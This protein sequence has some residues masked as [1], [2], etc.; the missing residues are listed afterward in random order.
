MKLILMKKKQLFKIYL[1]R[2]KLEFRFQEKPIKQY[3]MLL[4]TMDS[5]Q[6]DSPIFSVVIHLNSVTFELTV[7]VNN[8]K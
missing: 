8:E 1:I 7:N 4:A 2:I 5:I 6:R 3:I